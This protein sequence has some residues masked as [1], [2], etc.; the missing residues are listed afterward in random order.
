VNGPCRPVYTAMYVPCIRQSVYA[1]VY[2]AHVHEP[3]HGR[4]R[5]VYTS[6]YARVHGRVRAVYTDRGRVHGSCALYYYDFF[7]KDAICAETYSYES[8]TFKKS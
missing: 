5:P 2:T 3:V 8:T 7:A 6:M 4:V 1:V